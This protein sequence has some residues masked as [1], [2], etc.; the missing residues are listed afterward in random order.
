MP[1]TLVQLPQCYEG[2]NQAHLKN[3]NSEI[4]QP[5]RQILM[6]LKMIEYV[7]TDG[8]KIPF[9]LSPGVCAQPADSSSGWELTEFSACGT[10]LS[11]GPDLP[12]L[13]LQLF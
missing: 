12:G 4:F 6:D 1:R 3:S 10:G 11:G 2:E 7:N 8:F 9:P 13:V 5:L